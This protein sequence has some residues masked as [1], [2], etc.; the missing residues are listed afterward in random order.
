MPARIFGYLAS[1]A[2]AVP[3][4]IFLIVINV[5]TLACFLGIKRA[6]GD[7]RKLLALRV[8]PV[9]FACFGA[10]LIVAFLILFVYSPQ[11][12]GAFCSMRLDLEGII[13]LHDKDGHIVHTERFNPN[14]FHRYTEDD[15]VGF[16]ILVEG[17]EADPYVHYVNPILMDLMLGGAGVCGVIALIWF[18]KNQL[19]GITIRPRLNHEELEISE[20]LQK[21]IESKE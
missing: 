15:R 1:D 10:S 2:Y 9:I 20:R 18:A 17:L 14:L 19:F 6:E 16:R 12:P 5:V 21:S 11:K 8:A 3:Y 7:D 4:I 13:S